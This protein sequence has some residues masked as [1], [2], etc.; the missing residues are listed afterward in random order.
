MTQRPHKHDKNNKKAMPPTR[1]KKILKQIKN[2]VIFNKALKRN[3]KVGIKYFID[4]SFKLTA[5]IQNYK[6]IYSD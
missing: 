3:K 1:T 4:V 2:E 5:I 6:Y